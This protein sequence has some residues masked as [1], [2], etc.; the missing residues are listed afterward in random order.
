MDE[1]FNRRFLSFCNSL[2]G[3]SEARQRDLSDSF[4]L[5]GTSAKFSITFDLAWKVMKDILVQYYAI[6]GFVTGSPRE[7]LREAYK[8]NLISDDDWMEMLKVRNE[9]AHD[10][11][12]E[13]VKTHCD[14]IV[15]TYIDLFYDFENVVKQLIG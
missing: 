8:A 11:D 9:L 6:T 13:I 7:V 15:E 3:L 14:K 4:V 10:Y 12:C 5:S 1:K 2:D